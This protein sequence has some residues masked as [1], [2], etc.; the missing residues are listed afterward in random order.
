VNNKQS[1]SQSLD[2]QFIRHLLNCTTSFYTSPT[3]D[4][5]RLF[6]PNEVTGKLFQYLTVHLLSVT[7]QHLDAL[8]LGKSRKSFPNVHN[9]H[10]ADSSPF[11]DEMNDEPKLMLLPV[12]PIS[13][14][15]WLVGA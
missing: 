3:K 12:D 9:T 11:I 6:K 5:L 4:P 7:L 15:N 2:N 10:K 8:F 13:P 14:H 1:I